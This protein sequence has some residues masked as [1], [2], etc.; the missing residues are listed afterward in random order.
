MSPS[1]KIHTVLQGM[2]GVESDG[3][4]VSLAIE[5]LL[6]AKKLLVRGRFRNLEDRLSRPDERTSWASCEY[7]QT[8]V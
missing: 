2:S 3:P 7:Q 1:A 8:T 6:A 4:L 5:V